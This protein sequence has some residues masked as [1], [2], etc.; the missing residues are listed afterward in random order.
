M[1]CPYC[2]AKIADDFKVCPNC[3]AAVP[4]VKPAPKPTKK[5]K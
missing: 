4:A 5:S 3:K 1:T 2:R